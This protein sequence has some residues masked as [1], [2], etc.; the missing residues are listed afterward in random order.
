MLQT[1]ARDKWDYAAAAHLL[2]RAGF[3]GPPAEI[4]RL[5]KLGH[6]RAVAHLVDYESTPDPGPAPAWA[7]PDPDRLEK[8]RRARLASPEERRQ[9]LQ[10]EQRTQREHLIQL[11]AWWL[12]RMAKGPRPL[13]EKLVLFWHGHFATSIIKV[14]DAYLMW[15]QNDLFRRLGAGS[16]PDLLVAVGK[17]PAMLIWLDQAQSRKEHPNENFAREAM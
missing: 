10:Q 4:E 6:E 8:L 11:R 7:E 3:G 15:R 2:N 13:Q 16:W 5:F 14:R 1:L 17:D 12:E 9:I